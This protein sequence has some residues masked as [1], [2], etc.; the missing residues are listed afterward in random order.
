M[1]VKSDQPVALV[2]KDSKFWA[3]NDTA[4]RIT[5]EDEGDYYY[6][7]WTFSSKVNQKQL[8]A[9]GDS[10]IVHSTLE[11][12]LLFF[13]QGE[14]EK[15]IYKGVL[16]QIIFSELQKS[17]FDK[18]FA[19]LPEEYLASKEAKNWNIIFKLNKLTLINEPLAELTTEHFVKSN[20][21]TLDIVD[22][23]EKER[24]P[25]FLFYK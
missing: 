13:I 19:L 1:T 17:Y 20:N 22:Y 25:R 12:I 6:I 8:K 14:N 11:H 16:D 2:L 10:A 15:Q 5:K 4:F 7:P 9:L 21:E 24:G 18:T 23:I 3:E